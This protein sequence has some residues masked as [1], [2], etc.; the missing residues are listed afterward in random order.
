MSSTQGEGS[1]FSFCID[2]NKVSFAHIPTPNVEAPVSHLE[3]MQ[4]LIAE[5]DPVNMMVAT[6]ILE[7]RK[8]VVYKA[9]N[10]QEVLDQ[11]QK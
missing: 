2:L 7:S 5:D 10:G 3:N 11:L 4:V 1:I 9:T 6:K 8:A